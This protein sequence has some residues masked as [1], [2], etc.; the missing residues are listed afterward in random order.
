[1]SETSNVKHADKAML[2]LFDAEKM[3]LDPCIGYNMELRHAQAHSNFYEDDVYV[4]VD[5]ILERIR[6]PRLDNLMDKIRVALMT[7]LRKRFQATKNDA[8]LVLKVFIVD[9]SEGDE[10]A[11]LISPELPSAPVRLCLA[12]I[13]CLPDG[14][15]VIDGGRVGEFDW[16]F[17][18]IFDLLHFRNA[19]R[20]LSNVL[21]PKLAEKIVKRMRLPTRKAWNNHVWSCSDSIEF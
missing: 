4:H 2:S 10:E 9:A 20:C 6:E 12:W 19:E 5:D 16:N 15:F 13:L 8:K 11:R 1:M 14:S 21:V 18:G 3:L 7:K 17:L